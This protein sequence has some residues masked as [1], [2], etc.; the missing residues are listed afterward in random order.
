MRSKIYSLFSLFILLALFP[1]QQT[2]EIP[3]QYSTSGYAESHLSSKKIIPSDILVP[4]VKAEMNVNESGALTYTLPIEVIKG[5]NNFQP[6]IS[7]TYNSLTG[8]GQA[9]WGWNIIGLSMISRGGKSKEIDGIT[10][11]SQF[12]NTDPY[13]LDGQRLIKI[14]ETTFSTERFSKLKVSKPALGE[15]QFIIQYPDG[16]VAKYKELINGQFYISSFTD[17]FN[18]EIHYSYQTENNVPVITKISYGGTSSANDKFYINFTYKARQKNIK[19]FRKGISYITSKVLS[20][21][22]TGSTYT[23]LYRKYIFTH[24]FIEDNTVE[25]LRTV[26]VTNENGES[27]KPLNFNYNISSQGTVKMTSGSPQST[28]GSNTT[29]LGSVTV[30]NF[31]SSDNDKMQPVFQERLTSGYSIKVGAGENSTHVSGISVN[32]SGTLLFSGKVLD[33]NNRIM[34]KDQLIVVNEIPVGTADEINPN[35]PSNQQLKDEVNFEIKNLITGEQRK[36]IVPVKGGM[37]EVQTYIPPDPYDNYRDGTYETSY[38]R[39]ETRREYVQGDFNNDGLVDFLIIEPK[40]L[41]RGNRLYWVEVG[42]QNSGMSVQATPVILNETLFLHG[43]DIYPIEFDGDGIP[44]L[45]IVDKYNAKYSVYKINFSNNTLS[46]LVSNAVLSNFGSKT[47]LFLGDFNGDGLTDF[48][49]PQTVYEIPEDD[50]SGL[51][52]ADTYYRMQ[53]ETLLWWKYTG[54]GVSLEKKQED[55]TLQKIAYLKP[56]QNNYIK[57]TT[58]WQKF[59]NG[60]PDEY[61]YTRYSTHNIIITDFNNDG[62]SDIITF[63]KIGKAKYNANGSLAGIP[64]DN[65]GSNLT[66]MTAP[67]VYESFNSVIA[68]R[69]NFYENKNLNG[70]T[71]QQ[72]STL[73]L[74]NNKISPLSLIL[75]TKNF[76]YLNTSQSGVYIYDPLIGFSSNIVIDNSNFLEKQIQEVNNGTDVLQK[77]EYRNMIP[78]DKYF[79]QDHSEVTYLYRPQGAQIYP[80]YVHKENPA[81]Y[82]VAKI[83]TLF[84]NKILTKEYRYENGIQHLEGK[85]FMGFQKTYSSDAYESEIKD[86][87]YINKNPVNA[88]FWNITT[89]LPEMDNAVMSSTYGGIT[90]FFTENISQNKKFDIGNHQYLILATDEISIDYLKN[91]TIR[92]K[93]VYDEADDLKLKTAYT[94]FSGAGSS[95]SNYIYKPEFSNGEHYFYGKI[96]SVENIVSKD[97]LSFTTRDESDY[98]PDGSVSQVRKYGNQSGAAPV[99]TA[100]TYD[101][102][103]NLKTQTLS[104]AGVTSQ[105]TTYEYET[106]GRY[107]NKT[108]TPHGLYSTAIIDALGRTSSEVSPLGLTTSYAYDSWGNI[109]EITDFLGKKTTISKSAADA[110]T[111]GVYNLHKKREE[112]TETV[113][114][115]DKFDREVQ[116]KTQS[117]NGKW[118]AVKTQYDILG[119]K[120]KFSEP[121]YEGEP[122]RWNLIEYDELSRPAKNTDYKGYE[123]M[124]CYEGL[125]VTVDDLLTKKT[126]KTLD[127]MGHTIRQQDQGGVINYYYYPNGAIKE[128]NYEGIKTTFEI[129]GWGNKT[130]M[131]DPSAGTFTYEYDTL[132]RLTKETTPKGYTLYSYDDLGR[133]LTEKTYGNTPAENTTIEKTYTYNG[134]TKLP[135]TITGL[136]NGKTFIYT[137]YYD[138]YF[139][140]KGKKEQTP[141]FTYTSSTTFDAL[142][143]ADIVSMST[144]LVNPNYTS[145]SAVKNVYDTNGI[146]IQQNDNATGA[147]IWH[148]SD[149]SARGQ[150]K[151][152]EYGNGYTLVNQYYDLDYSLF[153]IKHQNVNNG[154]VALDMDYNQNSSRGILNFRR[155]N[156][157]GKK[158]DFTYDLLNRLLTEAVNG[159]ITNQYTYDKRGRITSNTELGKYNY[160]ETDYRLQGIDFNTNGQN[161]NTQRGFATIKYNA[162]KSPLQITL[163]GKEDLSFDYNILKTRY[164]MKSSV[165]GRQKFYSSDFAVEITKEANGKTQLITYVTGDPYTANYIKKEVLNGGTL[166]E[167]AN[168][169]LHRDNVGSIVAIS[170]TDGS[171]VEKRF[172]DAWGNLKGIVNAAGQM[173]TDP[174][175]ISN[176]TSFLDRGYTGH[177]H[178]WKTGLINMNARLYD[179]VLRRFLS[180]DNLVQDPFNTQSYNRFGYVYNNPLLY[181]DIDGNEAITLGTAIIIGIAVAITTKA[182][183]NMI[184]GIPVWY[185]MGKAAVMGAVSGA[186]SFGIGAAATSLFGQ[187]LTVGKAIFEAG[188]HALTSGTMSAIDGGKFEAGALS[189]AISSFM[190]SGIQSLGINFGAST[191]TRTVYN[192]FGRDYMKATMLAMGGLSGGISSTIAGGNFWDGF[193][194]GIITSG[195]NHLGH[196]AGTAIEYKNRLAGFLVKNG[197]MPYDPATTESLKKIIALFTTDGQWVKVADEKTLADWSEGYL[198]YK[199]N[200]DKLLELLINSPNSQARVSWAITNPING[201]IILAPKLLDTIEENFKA[202]SVI[203]HEQ[204]HYCNFQMGLL[205]GNSYIAQEMNELSAYNAAAQ[206]TGFMEKQGYVHAQN[207]SLFFFNLLHH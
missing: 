37:V 79:S 181:V 111:G 11:G 33:L 86:G 5:M 62:R 183:M 205:Q 87:K 35:N 116:S 133:P 179:P 90:K 52:L 64:I 70:G 80:Y 1:S 78:K 191:D 182:I 91:V 120:I 109:K 201:K 65:V 195:L 122:V 125:K 72:L 113:V 34:E 102:I 24:D 178:L 13:Y 96:A 22:I 134:Q 169:Y 82:L 194:Q 56:S 115:F 192:I 7:L 121:F 123:I 177:E 77:V 206:W 154:N 66:R 14:N 141:D 21:V 171:V 57:R 45:L 85:G 204:D 202:A 139:R 168:Y 6:N 8:N 200:N 189:G 207:V 29:G 63:N 193:R 157:F 167:N 124:T 27:L 174:T 46:T 130:K 152:S 176:Y 106:T 39:D 150:V 148:L 49:T 18:N 135:E 162:F 180:P 160:N 32:N 26:I 128:T 105:T 151:Q 2:K 198:P 137:T 92:K 74:E 100:Y 3:L 197:I 172:F 71:F 199:I 153:N 41:T 132:S 159:V 58:F 188:A 138:Q 60:K 144:T 83:H 31:L 140:I 190:A 146:L 15:Y 76:D 43:K 173:I 93:Y 104:A 147:M 99:V 98:F 110:S 155:N 53:T 19:I 143:R 44:E 112:G 95:I 165:T 9:G 184:S 68:N 55:Y 166:A 175:A 4:S 88:V 38:T 108:I 163:A 185:G 149:M 114:T 51:K 142:G 203:I 59:W 23:P 127:A 170:K 129:D 84:D 42:K 10:I 16:K 48:I 161:V 81:L 12:D 50:N 126:S 25:R 75:S 61:A 145:S 117:I 136:S 196:L 47:P 20:E 131:T 40:N 36:V 30:G 101:N 164:S 187:V 186:I 103:G 67:V 54:N 158:E 89:R 28:L 97:G 94:D 118:T 69:I 73:S 17:S 119:R 156:I 107:I